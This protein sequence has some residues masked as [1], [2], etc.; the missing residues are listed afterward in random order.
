MASDD[1]QYPP[2]G[3]AENKNTAPEESESPQEE[4][5]TTSSS[6][7]EESTNKNPTVT[8]ARSSQPTGQ[9]QQQTPQAE[10]HY[11]SSPPGPQSAGGGSRIF[12]SPLEVAPPLEGVGRR[13]PTMASPAPWSSSPMVSPLNVRGKRPVASSPMTARTPRLTELQKLWIRLIGLVRR[14]MDFDDTKLLNDLEDKVRYHIYGPGAEEITQT[15]HNGMQR[16]FKKMKSNELKLREE[17]VKQILQ[18][19]GDVT[20]AIHNS[21]EKVIDDKAKSTKSILEVLGEII[22]SAAT[23]PD[24]D[25][26]E[27]SKQPSKKLPDL[28]YKELMAMRKSS[29]AKLFMARDDARVR[30]RDEERGDWDRAD[31]RIKDLEGQVHNLEQK[32]HQERFKRGELVRQEVE[33]Q[34]R[35]IEDQLLADEEVAA[36]EA[37]REAAERRRLSA[38][39][40]YTYVEKSNSPDFDH[41]VFSAREV[42]GDVA[43]PTTE[44]LEATSAAAELESKKR[45][46]ARE[47]IQ[48]T[49]VKF[50]AMLQY[51][52]GVTQHLAGIGYSGPPSARTLLSITSPSSSKNYPIQPNTA[53]S[54]A[55]MPMSGQ[56]MLRDELD[57]DSL[58]SSPQLAAGVKAASD[59]GVPTPRNPH[60]P[61]EHQQ[62][63]T[64]NVNQDSFGGHERPEPQTGEPT[65]S[66]KT[67]NIL[68]RFVEKSTL[69]PA[70]IWDVVEKLVRIGGVGEGSP[71]IQTSLARLRSTALEVQIGRPITLSEAQLEQAPRHEIDEWIGEAE[72]YLDCL[73]NLIVDKIE[74]LAAL[75]EQ[76][77][78]SQAGHDDI[79][80]IGVQV[81]QSTLD[82]MPVYEDPE[83]LRNHPDGPCEDCWPV[84]EF[85]EEFLNPD[86]E[87]DTTDE[88]DDSE[89]DDEEDDSEEEDDDDSSEQQ[90][91]GGEGERRGKHQD[92]KVQG[93][94]HPRTSTNSHDDP[95][96]HANIAN[97]ESASSSSQHS[98][99]FAKSRSPH[100]LR[101]HLR[102]AR[103][104]LSR[105]GST[106]SQTLPKGQLTPHP[107][108]IKSSK[109]ST[110]TRVPPSQNRKAVSPM[111]E[112]P[113]QDDTCAPADVA[114]TTE[115]TAQ[116]PLSTSV[117]ET[118]TM[119]GGLLM[120]NPR[121]YICRDMAGRKLKRSRRRATKGPE[122]SGQVLKN[123]EQHVGE[124]QPNKP[125]KQGRSV[126][127]QQPTG[128]NVKETVSKQTEPSEQPKNKQKDKVIRPAED[129]KHVE[130]SGSGKGDQ[131]CTQVQAGDRLPKP[132]PAPALWQQ[133]LVLLYVLIR[134]LTWGQLVNIWTASAFVPLLLKYCWDFIQQ[135]VTSGMLTPDLRRRS[136]RPLQVPTIP[137]GAFSSLCL[138]LLL[139][140]NTT[141]LVSMKEERRLWLAANPRTA[142]YLRGLSNRY[143]Y[144]WWS[145]FEVDYALLEPAWNGFSV[146]L[147]EAYFRSGLNALAEAF[148]DGNAPAVVKSGLSY[149][150]HGAK[151]ALVHVGIEERQDILR[152]M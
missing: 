96:A 123:D 104:D 1:G 86:N 124:R 23:D 148:Y 126:D 98:V 74:L 73:A 44:E 35:K 63:E 70:R 33:V 43:L 132:R 26:D 20:L 111:P 30:E 49:M 138:W 45:Q 119:R 13:P 42:E 6:L 56:N 59:Q 9:Q 113:D 17:K 147:H 10:Q 151:V 14:E 71:P 61:S 55:R 146:W 24:A 122:S 47:A 136:L 127:T 68:A 109:G 48:E 152:V 40:H 64:I 69:A 125:P 76:P 137:G 120:R 106:A 139:A 15:Y 11:S 4:Q 95:G 115:P 51:S 7:P 34:V 90:R 25:K 145:P 60:I 27:F 143:P 87:P 100:T 112:L 107:S 38:D 57:S 89:E 133:L 94:E 82:D 19:V 65:P 53:D 79:G 116:E 46:A 97:V 135:E 77:S 66:T 85:E 62:P 41:P 144:P 21:A 102:P 149:L 67:L 114:P 105:E 22:E 3:S 12:S 29:L 54:G 28:H 129:E 37:A 80:D 110:S 117:P 134:W 108:T 131:R 75:L 83:W 141:M 84:L 58:A 103:L 150:A 8:P 78:Q 140:W 2:E 91:E 36:E 5:Q 128:D 142:S 31:A 72:P 50:D 88:E 118:L 81:P 18:E 101:R 16:F 99:S 92:E 121:G 52:R 130:P 39:F 32:L 93:G